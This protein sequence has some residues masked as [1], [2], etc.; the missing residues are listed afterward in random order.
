M[1][2]FVDLKQQYRAIKPEIEAAIGRV[3]E[4]GQYVLGDEVAAFEREVD[5][6]LAQR[7]V[8]G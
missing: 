2:P 6:E 7:T 4:T 5:L 3:L 1:I 8:V